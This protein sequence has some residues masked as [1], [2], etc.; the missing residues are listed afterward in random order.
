MSC[1]NSNSA[2]NSWSILYPRI[3]QMAHCE[4]ECASMQNGTEPDFR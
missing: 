3:V 4:Q 1:M 2:T